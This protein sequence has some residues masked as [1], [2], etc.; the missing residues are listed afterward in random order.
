MIKGYASIEKRVWNLFESLETKETQSNT[1]EEVPIL[2]LIE[3]EISRTHTS[4]CEISRTHTSEC[5]FLHSHK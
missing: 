4:E 3:C 2:N 5:E 1:T